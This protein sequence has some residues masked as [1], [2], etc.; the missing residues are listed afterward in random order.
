[1][2]CRTSSASRSRSCASSASRLPFRAGS[3]RS[4]ANK[5][6][7][8]ARGKKP[9]EELPELPVEAS[10]ASEVAQVLTALRELPEAYQETMILRLVEGMNGP[11]IAEQT[12]AVAGVGS[13]QFAPRHE[14][15]AGQAGHHHRGRSIR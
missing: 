3:S 7:D 8:H 5:A 10:R 4:R 15:L 14:A 12:G 13:C 1:M 9:T 2:W 11:E 6:L